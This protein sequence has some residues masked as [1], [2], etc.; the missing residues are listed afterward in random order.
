MGPLSRLHHHSLLVGFAALALAL[1]ATGPALA[2]D[3]PV[4]VGGSLVVRQSG[5]G[6][7]LAPSRGTPKAAWDPNA[8]AAAYGAPMDTLSAFDIDGCG[9]PSCNPAS[10]GN[11]YTKTITPPGG[12]AGPITVH[13]SSSDPYRVPETHVTFNGNS[14]AKWLGCCPYNATKVTLTDHFHVDGI[15][16]SVSLPPGVG[17]S[18]SGSDAYFTNSVTNNWA[19]YHNFSNLYF[20]CL[21]C[22]GIGE[23]STATFQFGN[24]F[25]TISTHDDSFV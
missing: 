10:L 6:L 21:D 22:V 1:S 19:I 2:H 24:Y 11:T 15:N 5:N 9:W 3:G 25:Y 8:D 14:Y 18:G 16:V 7:T 17:F 13:F 23:D 4:V 12:S 20:G